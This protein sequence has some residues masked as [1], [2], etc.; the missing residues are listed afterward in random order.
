M[1]LMLVIYEQYAEIA[2][3][4]VKLTMLSALLLTT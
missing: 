2:A 4:W 1:R 3:V